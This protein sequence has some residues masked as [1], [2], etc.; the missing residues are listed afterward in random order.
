MA[1]KKKTTTKKKFSEYTIAELR[2]F[3]VRQL[4]S[5]FL[6]ESKEHFGKK[7]ERV[8]KGTSRVRTA[9]A[10]VQA[11]LKRIFSFGP[12]KPLKK[13]KESE[14]SKPKTQEQMVKEVVEKAFPKSSTKSSKKDD[15]PFLKSKPKSGKKKS[16]KKPSRKS[17]NIVFSSSSTEH[18]PRTF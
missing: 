13:K 14:K 15:E 1:Q 12:V 7:Q 4:I 9:A 6:R 18:L 8:P 2:S 17:E 3:S 5:L 11:S 16:G 10:S